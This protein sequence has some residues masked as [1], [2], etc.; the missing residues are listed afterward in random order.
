MKSIAF[1]LLER[2][3]TYPDLH[4]HP[5]CVYF[6]NQQRP[7]G[8]DPPPKLQREIPPNGT[9]TRQL[10]VGSA[11]LLVDPTVPSSAIDYLP[12]LHKHKKNVVD[13]CDHSESTN[14][15]G[16][17]STPLLPYPPMTDKPPE[18]SGKVTEERSRGFRGSGIGRVIPWTHTSA[19][20]GVGVYFLSFSSNHYSTILRF[21][22]LPS[23]Q[24]STSVLHHTWFL[25][26]VL[27]S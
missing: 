8:R 2:P 23:F 3:P 7:A 1:F 5:A 24:S 22:S 13:P 12:S 20:I 25:F 9:S 17:I 21:E 27:L 26:L 6:V 14:R 15:N 10:L 16:D 18:A 4:P 19:V 11:I